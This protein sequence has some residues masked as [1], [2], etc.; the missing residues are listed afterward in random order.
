MSLSPSNGTPMLRGNSPPAGLH[1]APGRRM[2]PSSGRYTDV[3]E[4]AFGI[5][6]LRMGGLIQFPAFLCNSSSSFAG[7]MQKGCEGITS[8][9][10]LL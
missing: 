5:G 9:T 2:S 7:T 8:L 6:R 1:R 10:H 4:A 3:E